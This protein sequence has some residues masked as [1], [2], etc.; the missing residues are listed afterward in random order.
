MAHPGIYR[1]GLFRDLPNRL[2][3]ISLIETFNTPPLHNQSP[4]LRAESTADVCALLSTYLNSLPEPL[5]P[6]SL[7]A[8]FR[9]WCVLP[10]ARR[11][12]ARREYTG[13]Q[14]IMAWAS[15]DEDDERSRAEIAVAQTLLHLLPAKQFSLFVYL[16]AFFAQVPL[17]PENGITYEDIG[18]L[19][20]EALVGGED[21]SQARELLV[22]FLRR[23]KSIAEGLLGGEEA[24]FDGL[25]DVLHALVRREG[26]SRQETETMDVNETEQTPSSTYGSLVES[27]DW[28]SSEDCTSAESG[29]S[30]SSVDTFP[31]G[32]GFHPKETSEWT[33]NGEVQIFSSPM[34]MKGSL[35]LPDLEGHLGMW[36]PG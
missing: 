33:G 21:R 1:P 25:E 31:L 9:E 36:A 23:W 10:S 32:D 6:P 16:C 30:L 35:G 19:F 34:E 27:G 3:L 14:W 17:C 12:E 7:F 20:G 24:L 22:W 13:P 8:C 11:E 18:G 28:S 29:Y 4:S 26:G 5:I 15:R 2:R